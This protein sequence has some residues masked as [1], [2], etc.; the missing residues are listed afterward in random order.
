MFTRNRPRFQQISYDDTNLVGQVIST[1]VGLGHWDFGAQ[2]TVGWYCS[3]GVALELNYWGLYGDMVQSTVYASTLAG[4]LNTAY[5]FSPLNIGATNVND[6]F[7]AAQ[8]HRVRRDYDV[9][10]VEISLWGGRCPMMASGFQVSYLAG[11]RYLRFAEDFYYASADTSA[12]FGADLANEAYLDIDV[13]NNL[14]GFQLGGRADWHI[15]DRLSL[16]AAPK[17]GLYANYMEQRSRIYNVNGTAVVGPG[18]PLA[19]GLYDISS[20]ETIASFIG[21]VDLGLQYQFTPCLGAAIGYR[22]MA[23]SGLAYAT[24]QIPSHFADLPGVAAI[25]N[26]ADMILHGGYA[27]LTLTW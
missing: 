20:D 9:N 11:F 2:A 15:W 22:A 21:E 13:S 14:W 3:P 18:N 5:D 24:D 25:D 17:F 10:N 4:N 1:D 26:N 8:V 27:S 7:D 6:L 23:I 12:I 19:G 16:Y